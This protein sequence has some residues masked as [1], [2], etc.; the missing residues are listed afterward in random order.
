[1]PRRKPIPATRTSRAFFIV[2]SCF[3]R[4]VCASVIAQ[5]KNL[6]ECIYLWSACLAA[7]GYPAKRHRSAAL[8]ALRVFQMHNEVAAASWSAARLCRFH[9]LNEPCASQN[10][11]IH[12]HE[13]VREEENLRVLLPGI[14]G[15]GRWRRR[16]C[17]IFFGGPFGG[18]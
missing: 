3:C 16:A 15:L 7:Q 8:H 4:A 17:E 1:M 2:H 5:K 11:S 18:L 6:P 13:L 9:R 10:S 14:E 12:K